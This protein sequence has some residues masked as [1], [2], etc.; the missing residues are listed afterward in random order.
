MISK[1]IAQ[2]NNNEWPPEDERYYVYVF[3]NGEDILYVGT[4]S[5]VTSRVSEHLAGNRSNSDLQQAMTIN[6]CSSWEVD[7]Y[8]AHDLV[9][10][11]DL[12]DRCRLSWE[13]DYKDQDLQETDP[14]F[15]GV[16]IKPVTFQQV[17][18][19]EASAYRTDFEKDLI[20]T[21][22]P[23]FNGQC[24]KSDYTRAGEVRLRYIY[25]RRDE[26]AKR[27]AAELL[28]V[29]SRKRTLESA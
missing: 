22:S 20:L 1:T 19:F 26:K 2:L 24:P 29:P 27:K 5:Q 11:F 17:E 7:F 15:P 8:S 12:E 21:L 23:A 25:D 28:H 16:R 18:S 4:S 10:H 14:F 3:R 13:S 6:D 9:L